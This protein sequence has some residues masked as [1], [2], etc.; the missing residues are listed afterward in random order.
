[1]LEITPITLRQANDRR[2]DVTAEEILSLCR[3]YKVEIYTHYDHCSDALII[4][5][6]KEQPGI[7]RAIPA[8]N[9]FHS[10]FELTLRIILRN[11]AAELDR[12]VKETKA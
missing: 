2:R 11:M 3:E 8:R 5:M 1:M 12:K 6:R 7:E 9:I 10:G 4:R